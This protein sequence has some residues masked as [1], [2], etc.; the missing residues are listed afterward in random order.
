MF[1][2]LH[3]LTI[4]KIRV[5]LSFNIPTLRLK[6]R[7]VRLE[8]SLFI[9]LTNSYSWNW[10]QASKFRY[11]Y[12]LILNLVKLEF[13]ILLPISTD[14]EYKMVFLV[15]LPIWFWS[16][17]SLKLIEIISFLSQ[18][19]VKARRLN[20]RPNSRYSVCWAFSSGH[21]RASNRV[22]QVIRA[23]DD[24]VILGIAYSLL[25]LLN[26]SRFAPKLLLNSH[27]NRSS[28]LQVGSGLLHCRAGA[29]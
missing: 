21:F 11:P 16:S 13:R 10:D 22:R 6:A 20:T 25:L 28:I 4:W 12:L 26:P 7:S 24:F 17:L 8:L 5:G 23:D 27:W 9:I 19:F 29:V 15:I 3:W 14:L 18:V 1:T 2:R